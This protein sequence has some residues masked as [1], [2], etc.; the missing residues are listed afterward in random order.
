MIILEPLNLNLTTPTLV[1]TIPLAPRR[2][3]E[4]PERIYG[5]DGF[6]EFGGNFDNSQAD[7]IFTLK[8]NDINADQGWHCH[9]HDC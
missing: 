8:E 3:H 1:S 2:D 9:L 5:L 7:L 6:S 4:P